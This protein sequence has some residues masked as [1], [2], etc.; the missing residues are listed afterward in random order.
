MLIDA[1]Q[2]FEVG[3]LEVP[4]GEGHG[5]IVAGVDARAQR[6]CFGRFC[7]F[8]SRTSHC[9]QDDSVLFGNSFRNK[10]RPIG[11]K[12]S[13]ANPSGLHRKEE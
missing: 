11:P 12:F 9:A 7:P 5:A 13:T 4:N 2:R 1:P 8:V 3:R 6:G 10:A